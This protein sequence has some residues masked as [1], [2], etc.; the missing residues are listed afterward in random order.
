MGSLGLPGTQWNEGETL[1][2]QLQSR[3]LS[4]LLLELFQRGELNIDR[5]LCVVMMGL[6]YG[7][8]TLLRFAA[9]HL[10]DSSLACLRDSTRF[11]AVINPFPLTARNSMETQQ[12]RRSLQTLHRVLER[13]NH[14]EQVHALTT[15]FFSDEFVVQVSYL[16]LM[17]PW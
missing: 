15:A 2:A 6:G 9:T 5:H 3:A 11:L 14:H 17:P 1:D 16:L 12:V 8:N 4:N 13:G 7:A 10:L